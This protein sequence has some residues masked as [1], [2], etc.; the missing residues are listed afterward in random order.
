MQY[1]YYD[2]DKLIYAPHD[3]VKTKAAISDKKIIHEYNKEKSH[4][5]CFMNTEPPGIYKR[6]LMAENGLM[7]Y[8]EEN[9]KIFEDISY[10]TG[11]LLMH[12]IYNEL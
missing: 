1:Y 5:K 6:V 3:I 7:G 2:G 4:F 12:K 11:C 8:V 9:Y 10:K